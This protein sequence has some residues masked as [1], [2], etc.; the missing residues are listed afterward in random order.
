MLMCYYGTREGFIHT[1]W[2]SLQFIYLHEEEALIGQFLMNNGPCASPPLLRTLHAQIHNS[3]ADGL[4]AVSIKATP[5]T[6][7]L[8][9]ALSCMESK[10]APS[11]PIHHDATDVRAMILS[12][13]Y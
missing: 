11:P 13:Y 6:Q 10:S 8:T 3:C 4:V 1:R 5:G 9:L 2:S 7:L 12:K